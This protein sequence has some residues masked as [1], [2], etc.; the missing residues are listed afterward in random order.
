MNRGI[1][2][3]AVLTTRRSRGTRWHHSRAGTARCGIRSAPVPASRGARFGR[4]RAGLRLK[5]SSSGATC[6]HQQHE[7]DIAVLTDPAQPWTAVAPQA[8]WNGKVYYTFGA[9]TGQ[10]RRQVRPATAWTSARG[11]A[12]ARLPGRRQQHDR[13]GAQLEPRADERDGDDDEGA[14]RRHLRA[15]QVHDRHRLLGR[16]D[17]LEHERV[18]QPGPARR[19]GRRPAP[20]PIRRRPTLEVG[21][22]VL[23]VEAYQ[24]PGMA[25]PVDRADAGPDQR[26]EGRDQRPPRPDRLPCLVQRLRQQRPRRASTSSAW[27]SNN[28][29]G[30][31]T[32]SSDRHQQLRAAEQRGLRPGQPGRPRPTCRAATPGAGASRSRAACR[33][34]TA[35][36]DTARQRRR[37]VRPEGA[38]RAARSRPRS[39]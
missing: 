15:D 39:S 14:H 27:S 19:R 24:K 4:R 20:T 2:D 11:P 38:A 35:A 10:P 22:C 12:Q 33:A 3:I 29:T 17:Q 36:R 30:A 18:D 9:S 28:T 23:L 34:A 37:A 8:A 16:L 7:Y 1:Y 13:L 21:D 25:R 6:S 32:Q 26:Q 5:T 31:I